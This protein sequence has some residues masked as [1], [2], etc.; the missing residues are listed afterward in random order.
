MSHFSRNAPDA[1]ALV[2]LFVQ[3]MLEKGFLASHRFYVNYA[4]KTDHVDAYLSAVEEA[5]LLIAEAQKK[6]NVRECLTGGVAQPG[7][8]RLT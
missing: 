3:K 1:Q 4:Q 8:H 5:F 7:F 6:N 2:T